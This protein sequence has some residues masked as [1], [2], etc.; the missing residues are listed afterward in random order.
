MNTLLKSFAL[1]WL[2]PVFVRWLHQ[3]RGSGICFDGDYGSWVEAASHCTGYS[4]ENILA[5]VLDA[6][7][8]VK[9]GEAAFE[10]DSVLFNEIEYSWPVLAGLMWAAA[11]N[12]GRLNVLDFGGALGSS[13]FQNR[14]FLRALPEIRWNVVEQA[15]YVDAG[16]AHIQDEYLRFYKTIEECLI[17]NKPN[18]IVLSSV[19]Q[20]IESSTEIIKKLATIGAACLIVDRTPFSTYHKNKILIQRVAPSIY[21]ASYPMWVFSQVEFMKGLDAD[22]HLVA[23]NLSPE[24]FVQTPAKFEFSFQGML[25]EARR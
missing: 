8:R 2:P 12:G 17:N 1:D 7:L 4:A 16:Q 14:K 23:S 25:L 19:L 21:V 15:H 13:Y 3:K 18:V 6:T 22:W 24:A 11:R 5:K 10:R 20:Y 9:R